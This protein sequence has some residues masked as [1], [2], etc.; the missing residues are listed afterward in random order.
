MNRNNSKKISLIAGVIAISIFVLGFVFHEVSVR[1]FQ[2]KTC[3]LCHEMK[4]PIEN[5]TKSGTAV[6]H[7]N[8]AGCHY[9]ADFSGWLAMNKSAVRQFINHFKR[10]SEEPIELPKEPLFLDS[11]KEP[12]YWSL[13]PNSRCFQCKNAKNHKEIDQASIHNKLIKNI[14]NQPCKDCHNHEMREG[15]KFFEKVLPEADKN[16]T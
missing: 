9:T 4:R 3:V 6:N 13:V 10:D 8:C 15:Q 11:D 1:H 5:W 16:E 7:N 12:G 14:A 2:D